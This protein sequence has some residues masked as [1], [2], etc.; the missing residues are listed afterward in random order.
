MATASPGADSGPF[1]GRAAELAGLSA[2]RAA[3]RAGAGALVLVSGPPGIGKTRTVEEATTGAAV[4]WGRCVDDPGAPPL[5]PW[6]QVVRRRPEVAA[7]V[8]GALAE[9]DLRAGDPE[10]ARFRVVDTATEA[11]LAAAGPEGLVVVLEDLHW[12]D[13][14]SLRLLRHLAGELP[15]SRLLV[16]GTHRD[17]PAGSPLERALPELLRRP[18]A[19]ALP[20]GPL[21]EDDVVAYLRGTAREPATAS[22]LH[23]RSGGNPL[24]LRALTRL[25]PSEEAGPELRHLVRTSLAALAP[26]TLTL[27]EAAAVLG[28]EVDAELLADV[29]GRPAADVAAALDDAVRAGVLSTVPDLPGRRRFLHAVVRDV[30]SADLPPSLRE[31]L[32]RRAARAL[33]L[34]AP[35]DGALAGPVAGHWLRAART[36]EEW[37]TAAGWAR[38]AAA[39]ATRALAFDEA[40]RFLEAARDAADR[41]APGEEERAELLLELATARYRA[42][43]FAESLDAAAAA[44]DAA[45]ACGRDDLVAAAALV[46]QDVAA[47]GFPPALLR[48]AERAL[49]GPTAGTDP[50]LRARLLAQSASVLADAGRTGAAAERAGE[51]LALAEACGDPAAVL[52]AV[53]A[54]V[55]AAPAALPV[56]ER[57][58]LGLLAVDHAA[59]TGRPLVE[60]W[61][62]KWRIDAALEVGDTALAEEELDRVSALARRTR[63]PLVRWHDLRLRASLA[64]LTGRFAEAHALDERAREIALTELTQDVSAVGMS[65]AFAFQHAQVI[66]DHT[67]WDDAV[68]AALA[69]A[70]DVP[71][72]LVSR[73]VVLLVREGAEAAR[74]AWERLRRRLADDD[75]TSASGVDV[76]LVPLVEAFADAEAARVLA[77]QIAAHPY[78]VV[79]AGVY[80]SGS[81][82][83]LLGRLAVVRGRLDEAIGHF[84]EALEIDTGT[85]A[86]PAT[87]HDR[88]GLAGALLDRGRAADLPRALD[89]ARAAARDARRL[90]MPGLLRTADE[91]VRRAT[92]A[93]SA[94]DPLTPREREIAALVAAARTNRQIA[95][96][97][98]VSERTVESHVRNILGK[99]GAANRTELAARVRTG[100]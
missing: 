56:S 24:Y 89:L 38:R 76:N 100:G 12:A 17:P 69:R 37:R 9:V 66:G 53:R 11:L 64:A 28:E 8:A 94:A 96:A 50:A 54:R 35:D 75:F 68:L 5:W 91:L 88:T 7:A 21:G 93:R 43:R 58:R 98:V 29:T 97:L 57:L 83:A 4:L 22:R 67:A 81:T 16:V 74:P 60:L 40:A 33:E 34:R 48:L 23:R 47:P 30:V 80:C 3:A 44:S 51:A 95:E 20:L 31:D 72:V 1:V 59:T 25:A 15:R 85:G 6:R 61:G 63:L 19:R 52:D 92:A 62:A 45:A 39:A 49:A 18:A 77:A 55:K 36:P 71:I 2:A 14:T 26:G 42:G 13:D 10:A 79:G 70:D 84:E 65:G 73:A 46:V 86:V 27:L 78:A 82:A 87:V 90:G 99:L 41:A 32:H